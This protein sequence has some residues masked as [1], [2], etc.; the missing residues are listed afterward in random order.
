MNLN[1]YYTLYVLIAI[2]L[3]SERTI[4]QDPV[5]DL[6][7]VDFSRSGMQPIGGHWQFYWNRLL[8]PEDFLRKHQ[9]GELIWVP[10][11]W[12][13]QREY[14]GLGF[15]T[16]RIR[17][18]L[19]AAQS[20]VLAIYFPGINSAAK[21]WINGEIIMESGKVTVDK[22]FYRSQ[23]TDIML[24][25][26]P[27]TDNLDLIVQVINYTSLTGGFSGEPVI[28]KISELMSSLNQRQGIENFLA[29]S[30]I[31]MCIYQLI[32]YS[33]FHR[34][35]S[36]LWLALICLGVALRALIVHGGSFLLPNLFPWVPWEIWK[37]IEFVSVYAVIAFFP[38][39]IVHLF[40]ED[41]PRW[42]V[43]FFVVMSFLLCST[44]WVTP[45]YVYGQL[46]DVGHLALL[47]AFLY[48][49][50]SIGKAWKNGNQDAKTIFLGVVAAFPFILIEILKNS[51]LYPLAV[52]FMYLVEIGVLVFLLFQV[53]LLANHYANSYAKLES[54]N[55][56]LEK[57]VAERTSQLTTAN[58]VKDK[59]LSIVS[60]DIKSPLNSLRGILSIFHKGA[61]NAEEFKFYSQRVE[62]DLS[63]TSLLVDNILYWTA[64]QLN[65]VQVKFEEIDLKGIVTENIEL[66][67]T[68]ASN[69]RLSIKN[70]MSENRTVNFDRNILNLTLRNLISN[71]I[72]F[73]HKGDDIIVDDELSEGACIIRI[74][75]FGVGMNSEVI[76]S[77]E[78]TQATNS[79]AGTGN[80]KGTGLGLSFCREYLQLA[81]AELKIESILGKGSTLRISIPRSGDAMGQ[82]QFEKEQPLPFAPT[83]HKKPAAKKHISA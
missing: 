21:I 36:Y 7:Q 30:L 63:K 26:P 11:A 78:G 12:N 1:L 6:R 68:M 80:E 27:N 82:L 79:S 42:P 64:G 44:V 48:A 53:Y 77:V 38:L 3:A 76:K 66:F 13:Q 39:Y 10:G 47:F 34:G 23:L 73:S 71:A 45:H 28:G 22:K 55:Q 9:Q 20:D 40:H 5:V 62:G 69:K 4:A 65:G 52:Q 16:Y 83:F 59:L 54:L 57:I 18:K 46:L 33:I 60:H 51:L 70:E 58:R 37:K 56:N 75:D 41:A 31:A 8:T 43:K 17:L 81:G 2:F 50:Y 61:I 25:V 19:P 72:K 74:I 15:A 24:I 32:L 49:I 67:F 14:A 29:G 35:K